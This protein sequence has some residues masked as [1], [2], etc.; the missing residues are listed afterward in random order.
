MAAGGA[1][2]ALAAG[3]AEMKLEEDDAICRHGQV[4]RILNISAVIRLLYPNDCKLAVAGPRASEKPKRE[5]VNLKQ[6]IAGCTLL[7]HAGIT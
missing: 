1:V 4:E 3:G 7:T 6:R 5:T 2:G